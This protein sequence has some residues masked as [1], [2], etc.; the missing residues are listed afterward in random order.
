MKN[1]LVLCDDNEIDRKR[2][3]KIIEKTVN[4]FMKNYEICEFSN[5]TELMNNLEYVL[6]SDVAVLD[7]DM[8]NINGIDIANQLIEKNHLINIIFVT[9]RS[10][11]VFEAI[12]C[13]PFRFVRK[14]LMDKELEEAIE[15]VMSKIKDEIILYE[16]ASGHDT[17]KIRIKDIM[18]LESK[19]H[20]IHIH[21]NDEVKVIRG[22]ISDYE[23]KLSDYGFLRVHLG[24]LVNIRSIYSIT[25]KEITLDNGE[26]LPVSRKN[27]AMIKD[28]HANYVR[29]YVRGIS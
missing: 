14:E 11:L 17:I 16:F 27:I 8:P 15:A 13:R 3:R 10:D 18:Y 20:Y 23:T 4:L 7:I 21:T 22:K 28:K 9:N 12:R 29:R 5:G 19:S 2:E 25:S 26:K 1:R 24:Y 6:E